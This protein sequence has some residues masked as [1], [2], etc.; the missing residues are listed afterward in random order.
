[1]EYLHDVKSRFSPDFL[2]SGKMPATKPAEASLQALTEALGTFAQP[3]FTTM[4]KLPEKR[5][6][7][8]DLF[9]QV[10]EKCNVD[11][12]GD[13]LKVIFQL[14]KLGMVSTVEKARD[15]NN[16]IQALR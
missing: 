12:Y 15:G 9:N 6:R 11:N 1:M 4:D 13:F 3:I 7:T 10:G 2:I 14:E 5:I 8:M 16:L